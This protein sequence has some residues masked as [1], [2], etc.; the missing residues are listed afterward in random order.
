M[1]RK[2]LYLFLSIA[3][4]VFSTFYLLN[5]QTYAAAPGATFFVTTA[6]DEDDGACDPGDCSIREA[7][8]AANASPGHDTVAMG[9]FESGAGLYLEL[10]QIVISDDLT[11][12][13]NIMPLNA[14]L[15]GNRYFDITAGTAV[16][17]SQCIFAGGQADVGGAIRVTDGE[18]TIL[19]SQVNDNTVSAFGGGIAAI[20][21]SLTL[22]DTHFNGNVSDSDA[23]AIY[24]MSST[25]NLVGSTLNYNTSVG[26]GGAIFVD[27][28]SLQTD[29][30]SNIDHNSAFLGGGIAAEAAVVSLRNTAVFSNSAAN[31]GGIFSINAGS[32]E[33]RSSM[34]SGN[35][36]ALGG[37]ILN[38][39]ISSTLLVT[40]S[41]INANR[42][43]GA[44]AG[45][46]NDAGTVF[47]RNQCNLAENIAGGHGGALYSS[48][49][50]VSVDRCSLSSNTSGSNG[51]GLHLSGGTATISRSELSQGQAADGLGGGIFSSGMLS[52]TQSSIALNTAVSGGG[53]YLEADAVVEH[54]TIDQNEAVP[55]SSSSAAPYGGG[56][57][58]G[59]GTLSMTHVT[60]AYNRGALGSGLYAADEDA[61]GDTAVAIANSIVTLNAQAPFGSNCFSQATV[62]FSSVGAN[63]AEEASCPDFTIGNAA[64][65]VRT[66]E[67]LGAYYPLQSS[68]DALDSGDATVC[69]ASRQM[70]QRGNLLL[71]AD[72]GCDLGAIEQ[73]A[74]VLQYGL[75]LPIVLSP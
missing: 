53:L 72:A 12:L 34:V 8:A 49:G 50:S 9:A 48:S 37:G 69:G 2:I 18:L 45:I 1:N 39:G 23:G 56:V 51:G 26:R 15:N 13:C 28:G 33:L 59:K 22:I 67:A 46:Y 19:D 44:G 71:P 60:M 70:D 35:E 11:L 62:A 42:S 7:I 38:G 31:G 27:G 64:L 65:D 66:V 20:R 54:S 24:G 3:T 4:A 29:L 43:T 16:S 36:A 63:L 17:I 61:M 75:S 40:Q 5:L 55:S 14:G 68:S 73:G 57:F 32:V 47:L 58:I 25:I 30:N 6:A 10:G 74:I 52:V 41:G 21:S